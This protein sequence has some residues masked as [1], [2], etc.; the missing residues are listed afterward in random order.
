MCLFS[1]AFLKD[2]TEITEIAR[3][4]QVARTAA[5][6]ISRLSRTMRPRQT[7]GRG[8]RSQHFH[9]LNNVKERTG[10]LRQAAPPDRGWNRMATGLS[11]SCSKLLSSSMICPKSLQLFAVADL[12]FGIMLQDSTKASEAGLVYFAA[13]HAHG[14]AP[15]R[16]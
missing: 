15:A 1:F 14:T 9:N 11:S 10:R 3:G 12:R 13:T 2:A 5:S 4:M 6:C 8:S 16:A 7:S